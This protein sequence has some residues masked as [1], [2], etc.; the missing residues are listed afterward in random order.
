MTEPYSI[1]S[2]P[3][4]RLAGVICFG[5]LALA[6]LYAAFMIVWPFMTAILLGAI[7]VILTFGIF[8]RVRARLK[9][10]SNRAALVMAL[11]M[12]FLILRSA[13]MA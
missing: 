10:N 7:L 6:L 11:T 2:K 4:W 3:Q 12:G 1:E 13:E 5:L 9:G 8:R